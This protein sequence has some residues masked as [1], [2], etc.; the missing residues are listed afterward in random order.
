MLTGTLTSCSVTAS[1]AALG[2]GGDKFLHPGDSKMK[3]ALEREITEFHTEQKSTEI[4]R[5]SQSADIRLYAGSLPASIEAGL[6]H[7]ERAGRPKAQNLG[8]R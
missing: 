3:K 8:S 6:S 2:L 1:V 7:L 5:L 4:A